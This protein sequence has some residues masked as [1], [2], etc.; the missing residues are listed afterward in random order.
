VVTRQPLKKTAPHEALPIALDPLLTRCARPRLLLLVWPRRKR[1]QRPCWT[2][3]GRRTFLFPPLEMAGP[4][5]VDRQLLLERQRRPLAPREHF[6]PLAW[7]HDA[8]APPSVQPS[9]I[10]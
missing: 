8:A 7:L 1:L 10:P 3:M 6:H 5:H 4:K 9:A 2:R